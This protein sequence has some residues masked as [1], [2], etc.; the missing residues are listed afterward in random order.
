MN[1]P[2]LLITAWRQ[3]AAQYERDGVT[4]A[5]KLLARVADELEA[6]AGGETVTLT[7]AANRSGYCADH[8]RRLEKAGQLV[9]VGRKHAPRYRARDLPTKGAPRYRMSDV[10]DMLNAQSGDGPR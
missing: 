3:Q 4:M 1:T 2:T 8:L 6:I 7:E 9:N 10:S 5:A